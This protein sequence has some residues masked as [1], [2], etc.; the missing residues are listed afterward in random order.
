MN[1]KLV[2]L[3]LWIPL[4]LWFLIVVLP[5]IWTVL[6]SLKPN[7]QFYDNPW[8][9]PQS[10]HFDNYKNVWQSASI[11]DYFFNSVSVTGITLL[12]LVLFSSQAAYV[13]AR[14]RFPGSQILEIL[15]IASL[16]VPK[17]FQLIPKFQLIRNMGLLNTHF[18]L[19]L[20]YITMY[21]A[22]TS[23]VLI[24]FYRSLPKE[25]EEAAWIDGASYFRTYGSVMLPLAKGGLMTVIVLQFLDVWNDYIQ[26]LV[27]ISSPKKYTIPIGLV[28]LMEVQR[29]RTDWGALFAGLVISMIPAL[30]LYIAGQRRI[31][32]GITAGAVKG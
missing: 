12:F 1:K 2:H 13:L 7:S 9:F 14:F 11:G 6:T 4:F 27:F 20:I 32:E 16:F 5:L 31:T 15:L 23:F 24:G 29:F 8:L 19:D 30:L 25:L 3:L 10:L 22:F 17:M 18:G 26:P 28:N 21:F